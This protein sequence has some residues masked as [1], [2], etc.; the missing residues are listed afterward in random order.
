VLMHHSSCEELRARTGNPPK[1]RLLLEKC[2]MICS[3]YYKIMVRW[4]PTVEIVT[5]NICYLC[6]MGGIFGYLNTSSIIVPKKQI[7]SYY[8]NVA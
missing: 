3:V 7:V 2:L 5:Q 4:L 1:G 6:D 8:G